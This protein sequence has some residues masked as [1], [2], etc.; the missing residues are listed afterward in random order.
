MNP[1]DELW[2]KLRDHAIAARENAYAPYSGFRVGACLYGTTESGGPVM[3]SGCN[4]ENL[5]YGATIC[6]ERA[7]IGDFATRGGRNLER[8]VVVTQGGVTPCGICRQVLS[9]FSKATEVDVLCA[10]L[11]G[12]Y[13]VHKLSALLPNAFESDDVGRTEPER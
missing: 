1:L 3:S 7:A 10:D 6:A 11:D 13:R 9:E 8:I 2:H 12:S 4:V 5:S